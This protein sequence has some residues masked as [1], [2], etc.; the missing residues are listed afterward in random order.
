VLLAFVAVLVKQ[1]MSYKLPQIIEIFF[2]VLIIYTSLIL[3]IEIITAVDYGTAYDSVEDLYGILGDGTNKTGAYNITFQVRSCAQSDCSDGAWSSIYTNATYNDI[4]SLNNNQYF[5][6]RALFYTEDQNYTPML[7]NVTIGYTKN[8]YPTN[9][10]LNIGNDS[11][12]EWNQT[13]VFDY[14]ATINDTNTTPT[15]TS[16][17][18]EILAGECSCSGCYLNL[19][20]R[21]C[22]IPF[23]LSSATQGKLNLSDINITYDLMSL[24]ITVIDQDLSPIENAYV[25]IFTPTGN[26]TAWKSAY[27]DSNG[28]ASFTTITGK[29]YD[30]KSSKTGYSSNTENTNV[31]PDGSYNLSMNALI[32]YIKIYLYDNNNTPISGKTINLYLA[33]NSTVYQ[34]NTTDSNGYVEFFADIQNYDLKID[35]SGWNRIYEDISPPYTKRLYE[36]IVNVTDQ[37]DQAINDSL[38]WVY[39]A[40]TTTSYNGNTNSSGVVTFGLENQSYDI[41]TFKQGSFSRLLRVSAPDIINVE[42]D[43]TVI[44]YL[45]EINSSI[46]KTLT[47]HI[48]ATTEAINST[49][50]QILLEVDNLEELH[51]CSVSPNSTI[52]TLLNRLRNNT[53]SIYNLSSTIN[54]TISSLDLFR[55][56]AL[57]AGSPRY[58]NEES[59]IEA[60]FVGQNGSSVEPDIINVTIYDPNDNTWTTATKAQFTKGDDNIWHYAKSISSNPQTGM[61]TVHMTAEYEDVEA[62]KSTQFR[63]ATG[64]PYKVYLECPTTSYIGQELFCSVILKDEGESPT[65]S[66]STV[67]VDTNNNGVWDAGEP[68]TSF[69]KETVPL[70]NITES[71]SINVP[72]THPTGL[73][74]V[75]VDTSYANSAQP[76]SGASDSVMFSIAST[77]AE[78]GGSAGSGSVINA[79][80]TQESPNTSPTIKVKEKE[81]KIQIAEFPKEIEIK[82]SESLEKIIKIE[83]TGESALH[84]VKLFILGLPSEDYSITPHDDINLEPGE[85]QAFT[86][87][88]KESI[89]AKEYQIKVLLIS[90]EGTE[91]KDLILR[92]KETRENV[93]KKILLIILGFFIFYLMI[94]KKEFI[95][96]KVKGYRDLLNTKNTAI[97]ILIGIILI[98]IIFDVSIREIPLKMSNSI[99]TLINLFSIKLNLF[100]IIGSLIALVLSGIFIVLILIL[101]EIRRHNEFYNIRTVKPH[102]I[103]IKKLTSLHSNAKKLHDSKIKPEERKISGSDRKSNKLSPEEIKEN[104]YKMLREH[105]IDVGNSSESKKNPLQKNREDQKRRQNMLNQ[106]KR[107]SE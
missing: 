68:V 51:Q 72:S 35:P 18:N 45:D 21:T 88:L 84:N 15:L 54:Q 70:Q 38:V 47:E 58:A 76:N 52:C 48:N 95:K 83:N 69:S 93:P 4:S 77:R 80:E 100:F 87:N 8:V 102:K 53:E 10:T 96:K 27:T 107:I 1:K 2:L 22:K 74:V 32:D 31:A 49:V 41:L 94:K 9:V 89:E 30:I 103:S 65:E 12:R 20:D 37:N 86:I 5:Q 82:K 23:I 14:Q 101:K 62:S 59:L 106:L 46:S 3:S 25:E 92:V 42:L 39:E 19:T 61:Y 11:D 97:S 105:G 78:S 67:W 40:G 33:D 66:T 36:L 85:T 29:T 57:V 73:Y 104:V 17:L 56:S 6:Y 16:E 34:T 60:T 13:G 63:I 90:D 26:S 81:G 64:G 99:L 71:V 75:R 91:E 55:I 7:F 79:R 50:A 43:L 98:S 28:K 24:N 44:D